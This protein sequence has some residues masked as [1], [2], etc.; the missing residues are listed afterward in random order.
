MCG[1]LALPVL[2]RGSSACSKLILLDEVLVELGASRVWRQ[3]FT[4]KDILIFAG[5]LRIL[6]WRTVVIGAFSHGTLSLSDLV[7]I[8]LRRSL[9]PGLHGLDLA[10]SICGCCHVLFF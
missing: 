7:L 8:V 5:S 10:V 3:V 2:D 1:S 4:D 9:N 6:Y